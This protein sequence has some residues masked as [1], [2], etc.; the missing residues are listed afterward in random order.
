MNIGKN[1]ILALYIVWVFLHLI[2]FLTSG[3]FLTRYDSDFFPFPIFNTDEQQT[4]SYS[5]YTM[6]DNSNRITNLPSYD[7]FIKDLHND[8]NLKSLYVVIV[9][10]MFYTF[11]DSIEFVNKMKEAIDKY[12]NQKYYLNYYFFPDKYGQYDYSEFIIYLILPLVLTYFK[13]FWFSKTI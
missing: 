5:I 1:R 2:L 8:K 4:Y 9:K 7:E 6:L 10:K 11:P 12:N 13:K 3:N